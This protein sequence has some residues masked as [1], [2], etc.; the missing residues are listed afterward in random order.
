MIFNI[1]RILAVLGVFLHPAPSLSDDSRFEI[2]FRTDKLAKLNE[3]GQWNWDIEVTNDKIIYTCISCEA[4]TIATL[5]ATPASGFDSPIALGKHYIK[6]RK[7][8][9]AEAAASSSGRCI[10]TEPANL[11]IGIP[12]FRSE[13]Q[14]KSYRE[15][16]FVAF[17]WAPI[18]LTKEQPEKELL[19][20]TLRVY[21]SA[22]IPADFHRIIWWTH[23][24]R[25]TLV[26]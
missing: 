4:K 15:I 9:C 8:F 16:E 18:N 21:G 11:R 10:S 20:A 7:E 19:K 22:P 1:T 17:N 23:M 6:K 13:F 26:F 3:R 5:E 12:G 24:G 2:L 25:L 14:T